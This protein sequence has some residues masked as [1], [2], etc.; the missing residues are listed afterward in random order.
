LSRRLPSLDGF[1][2]V[3]ILIVLANHAVLSAGF[4]ASAYRWLRW[5]PDGAIGVTIFFVLSGF[6]ITTVLLREK[7]KGGVDLPRFYAR[8]ALRTV[9]ACYLFLFFVFVARRWFPDV[10]RGAF[11]AALAFTTNFVNG[12]T[13]S[14]TLGHLWTLGVEE[15]FYAA[16]PWCVRAGRR[17]M[18][19]AAVAIVAL[20]PLARAVT[21]LRPA[22]RF[23]TLAPFFEHADALMVGCLIALWL[24][25]RPDRAERPVFRSRA[26]RAASVLVL[27]VIYQAFNVPALRLP[28]ELFVRSIVSALAGYLLVGALGARE[29]AAFRVL[30]HRATVYVGVL[31]YSLYLWQQPFLCPARLQGGAAW[32][33]FP[34]NLF[35]AVAA[36]ALSY[37]LWEKLF[38]RAKERF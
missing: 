16:W 19:A 12:A 15:Q 7:E 6:L 32:R 3:S 10:H 36:A 35:L 2:A 25:G 22:W 29:G 9:P 30:N 37:H 21:Q 28:A 31:S 5:G 1:R 27:C 18:T 34:L 14:W 23:R 4:P 24:D 11:V 26:L 20:A 33:A 17:A 8:R 38:L 13:W